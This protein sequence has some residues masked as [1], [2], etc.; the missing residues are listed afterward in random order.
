MNC[1]EIN[2]YFQNRRAKLKKDLK[3][4]EENSNNRIFNSM[5]FSNIS[6]LSNPT[7]LSDGGATPSPDSTV[8]TAPSPSLQMSPSH[9]MSPM[10]HQNPLSP[11]DYG[12]VRTASQQVT[13]ITTVGDWQYD[14]DSNLVTGFDQ[15]AN[16][17]PEAFFNE[18]LSHLIHTLWS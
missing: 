9:P 8:Q 7:A 12:T 18:H 15:D 3:K 13:N 4:E 17:D 10:S 1:K 14:I 16:Y 6:T 2:R 5:L 11:V